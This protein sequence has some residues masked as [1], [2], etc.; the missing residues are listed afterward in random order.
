[1]K[2]LLRTLVTLRGPILAGTL[3]LAAIGSYLDQGTAPARTEM[4]SHRAAPVQARDDRQAQWLRVYD[5]CSQPGYGH[6][7]LCPLWH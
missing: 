6:M 5:A 3:A 7:M 4:K 1:M 2:R